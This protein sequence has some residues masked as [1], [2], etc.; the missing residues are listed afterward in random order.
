MSDV[1]GIGKRL[2]KR[3]NNLGIYSVE[4]LALANK[5]MLKKK[6]GILG[7]ELWWHANGID[8]CVLSMR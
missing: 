7:T 1:W 8:N 2:E 4:D 3:L 5:D 6:F